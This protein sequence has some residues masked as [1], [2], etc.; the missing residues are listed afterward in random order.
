MDQ[1]Y[2]YSDMLGSFYGPCI[3]DDI[4]SPRLGEIL[5][6]YDTQESPTE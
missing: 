4:M 2:K 6:L 3:L 5:S 1:T